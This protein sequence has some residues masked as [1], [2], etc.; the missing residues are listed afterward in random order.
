MKHFI[1]I[2]TSAK[3]PD[4]LLHRDRNDDGEELVKIK[5]I[6]EVDGT[7]DMFAEETIIFSSPESAINF[8]ADFSKTSAEEWC[9]K[10]RITYS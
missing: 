3:Y 7:E 4:V 1:I 5:A 8:I 6:G 10:E 9:K 2:K